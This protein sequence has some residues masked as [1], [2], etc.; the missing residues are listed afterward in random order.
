MFVV[1][2]RKEKRLQEVLGQMHLVPSPF[3]NC[4]ASENIALGGRRLVFGPHHSEPGVYLAVASGQQRASE[5]SPAFMIGPL[6]DE[7]L[8]KMQEYFSAN[9]RCWVL[10]E[11]DSS[12]RILADWDCVQDS[13]MRDELRSQLAPDIKIVASSDSSSSVQLGT[14]VGE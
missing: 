1:I 10:Y 9:G 14:A 7:G 4:F 2:S 3:R 12:I 13:S 8:F 11:R 6:K 5:R